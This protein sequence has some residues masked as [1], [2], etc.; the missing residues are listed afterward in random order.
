[1]DIITLS[2]LKDVIINHF[3]DLKM[4]SATPL[5]YSSAPTD[6]FLLSTNSF[7]TLGLETIFNI[8]NQIQWNPDFNKVF[9]MKKIIQ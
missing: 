3:P 4:L 8:V 1:M 7:N 5:P 9:G 6:L 2:R